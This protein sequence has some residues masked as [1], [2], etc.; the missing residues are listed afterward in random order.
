MCARDQ[1]EKRRGDR[2]RVQEVGGDVAV[3][4]VDPHQRPALSR[5]QRLRGRD[6]DQQRPDQPGPAGDRERVDLVEGRA[7][8]SQRRVDD[9]VDQL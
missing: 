1:A 8:V 7:G 6:A 9:R 3:E 4:M 2:V 5:G